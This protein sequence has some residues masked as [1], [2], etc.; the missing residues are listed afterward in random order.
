MKKQLIG[1]NYKGKKFEIE[2]N[3]VPWWYEGIGLMFMK[4]SSA[5]ILL[6]RFN[7]EVRRG[8]FSFFIPF[9][10]LAVWI[11]GKGNVLEVRMVKPGENGIKPEKKFKKLI[12]IPKSK[13]YEEIIKGL[14]GENI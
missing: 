12:E 6:F 1:F 9:D 4:K 13:K 10:F 2:V 3:L 8:I 11:D 14:V 7:K 5:K